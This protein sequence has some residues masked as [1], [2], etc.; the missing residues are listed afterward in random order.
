M[1]ASIS[2]LVGREVLAKAGVPRLVAVHQRLGL[3]QAFHDVAGHVLG[4]VQLGLLGQ[5]ADTGLLRRPSLAD[6]LR[7]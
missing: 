5:I 7:P 3:G 4:R 2:H 6:E 1:R